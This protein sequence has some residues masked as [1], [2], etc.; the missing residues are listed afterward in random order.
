M[1]K[2]ESE[3]EDY[4][5]FEDQDNYENKNLNNKPSSVPNSEKEQNSNEN[6]YKKKFTEKII[7]LDSDDQS[8]KEKAK[9]ASNDEYNDPQYI[10]P[11]PDDDAPIEG[12]EYFDQDEEYLENESEHDQEQQDGIGITNN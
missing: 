8:S 5:V 11:P 2:S 7:G 3:N 6:D 1:K 4:E 12:D 9:S 10:H